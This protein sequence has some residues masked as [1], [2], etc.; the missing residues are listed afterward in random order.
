MGWVE[1]LQPSPRGPRWVLE[2]LNL[3]KS[4]LS[5]HGI[6]INRFNFSIIYFIVV[7]STLIL[8]Y[9]DIVNNSMVESLTGGI[10][11]V[12]RASIVILILGEDVDCKARY[13]RTLKGKNS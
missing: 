8:S 9:V 2:L 13:E 5:Y 1:S 6:N 3:D 4:S 11:A 12:F 10:E 7:R